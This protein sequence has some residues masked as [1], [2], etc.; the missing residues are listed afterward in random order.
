[1]TARSIVL[2]AF[3]IA[4]V[5]LPSYGQKGDGVRPTENQKLSSA[6]LVADK[7]VRRFLE[8]LDFSVPYKEFFTKDRNLRNKNARLLRGGLSVKVETVP[9]R[10]LDRIYT[11]LMNYYFLSNIWDLNAKESEGRGKDS[12]PSEITTA[13]KSSSYFRMTMSDAGSCCDNGEDGLRTRAEVLQF[14]K[15]ATRINSL[16]RKHMPPSPTSSEIYQKNTK[17]LTVNLNKSSVS[18][19]EPNIG[20]SGHRPVYKVERGLFFFYIF[21]ESGVFKVFGLGIGN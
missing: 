18:M 11:E 21:E 8:T 6:E 10:S 12:M 17:K 16:F 1:M 19:G 15:A 14:I 7:F 9:D 4:I 5:V 13:I 2:L 20:V 3:L